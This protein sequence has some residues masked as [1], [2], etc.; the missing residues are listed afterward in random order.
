MQ[1]LKVGTIQRNVKNE[2]IEAINQFDWLDEGEVEL[3]GEV[4]DDIDQQESIETPQSDNTKPNKQTT[5]PNAVQTE[6][7]EYEYWPE[8]GD[9]IR[10]TKKN[11]TTGEVAIVEEP[12]DTVQSLTKNNEPTSKAVVL[13]GIE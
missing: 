10:L 6:D 2:I 11:V 13:K 9:S 12:K 8:L 1:Y 4:P 7:S 3:S 5:G